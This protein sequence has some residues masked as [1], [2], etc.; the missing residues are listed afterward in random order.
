METVG[1]VEKSAK[2]F[3]IKL[4]RQ[5]KEADDLVRR[6]HQETVEEDAMEEP[7]ETLQCR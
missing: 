5:E 6:V 3:T 4:R 1:P 2:V 7:I